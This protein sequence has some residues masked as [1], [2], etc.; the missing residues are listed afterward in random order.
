MH[1]SSVS[2]K[3]MKIGIIPRVEVEIRVMMAHVTIQGFSWCW[4][5]VRNLIN[6]E[7][8]IFR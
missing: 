4:S 2:C 5:N 1:Y 7:K 8:K 6:E 3:R